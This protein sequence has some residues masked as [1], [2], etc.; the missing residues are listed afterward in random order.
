MTVNALTSAVKAQ[1]AQTLAV[2]LAITLFALK[3]AQVAQN[4]WESGLTKTATKE[5]AGVKNWSLST[6]YATHI[7][8]RALHCVGGYAVVCLTA[9][10]VSQLR[11]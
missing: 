7:A 1:P 11:G 3:V 6:T 8:H 4:C 10:L 9:R 5:W 2:S